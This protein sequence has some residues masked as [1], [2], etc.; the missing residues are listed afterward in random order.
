M[1]SSKCNL[2][3]KQLEKLTST[4]KSVS[5]ISLYLCH[6]LGHISVPTFL[7]TSVLPAVVN[8]SFIWLCLLVKVM[9]YF[10]LAIPLF[11]PYSSVHHLWANM[12][13]VTERCL[14]LT[15]EQGNIFPLNVH[16]FRLKGK[17]CPAGSI[18]TE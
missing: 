9:Y 10:Q 5:N 12:L 16:P 1:A 11:M 15:D 8:L 4:S 17:N 2:E 18:W 6:T 13:N 7:D 3:T 14:L